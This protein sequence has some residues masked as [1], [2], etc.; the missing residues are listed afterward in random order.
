MNDLERFLDLPDVS[1]MTEEVY[2]SERLGKV[3]VKPMTSEEHGAYQKRAQ[4]K[5]QKGGIDFDSA[6]FNLLIVAGQT[7]SPNF[8]DAELLKKSGC[9]TPT[10]FISRKLKAGEIAELAAQICKISGFD[11]DIN[12]DV[13]EAK[14]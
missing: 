12:D 11:E 3:T 6:K 10:E 2:V 5:V 14:N 13:A 7:I 4:G 1:T 8:A 9:A